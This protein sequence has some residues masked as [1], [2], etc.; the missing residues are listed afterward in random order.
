MLPCLNGRAVLYSGPQAADKQNRQNARSP[1]GANHPYNNRVNFGTEPN[2]K[3]DPTTNG[4]GTRPVTVNE[5]LGPWVE[6][7]A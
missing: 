3:N 7:F 1:T 4:A 6:Q 5:L 2:T